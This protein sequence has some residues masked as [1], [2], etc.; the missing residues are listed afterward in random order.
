M[1]PKH[2]WI[3][4]RGMW[5]AAGEP[6]TTDEDADRAELEAALQRAATQVE[7]ADAV[8]LSARSSL[9]NSW[10]DY[11]RNVARYLQLVEGTWEVRQ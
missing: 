4:Y 7:R 11:V 5:N 3:T 2:P 10:R 8:L 1:N 9:Y 6:G